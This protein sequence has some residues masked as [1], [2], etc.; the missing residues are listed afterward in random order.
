VLSGREVLTPAQSAISSGCRYVAE[1]SEAITT[2]AQHWNR[3]PKPFI[4]KAIATDII[5]K[6]QRGR[7][8]LNHIKSQTEH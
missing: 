6:V 7:A 3:D 5:A 1:L 2:W 4:W 8:T